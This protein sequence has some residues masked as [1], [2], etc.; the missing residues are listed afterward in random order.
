MSSP[1]SSPSRTGE[2][3]Q[4]PARAGVVANVEVQRRTATGDDLRLLRFN[5]ERGR[6]DS[7]TACHWGFNINRHDPLTSPAAL[8]NTV[9]VLRTRAGFAFKV[10][11]RRRRFHL[12]GVL[13]SAVRKGPNVSVKM[14]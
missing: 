8:F 12:G 11:R 9:L 7:G 5:R 1:S 3:V 2:A 13:A 6:H 4:L 14:Q 10:A